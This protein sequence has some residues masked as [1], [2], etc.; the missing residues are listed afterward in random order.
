MFKVLPFVAGDPYWSSHA[1]LHLR[2]L[3]SH[4]H[5]YKN[6]SNHFQFWNPLFCSSKSFLHKSRW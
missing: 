4:N 1:L 3:M 2:F 6:T 5:T